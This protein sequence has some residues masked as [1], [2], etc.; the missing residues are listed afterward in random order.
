MIKTVMNM[1]IPIRTEFGGTCCVPR[2][3]LSRPK[4]MIILKKL[5]TEIKK[6]GTSE[7]MAMAR[8]ICTEE[9]NCGE[10][11]IAFTFNVQA[12]PLCGAAPASV[13]IKMEKSKI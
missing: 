11:M 8:I 9:V 12:R 1:A 13:D 3:V 6:K 2:A 7:I 5:V 10:A 4:T